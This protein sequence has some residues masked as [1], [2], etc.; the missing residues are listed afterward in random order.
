M[1][2]EGGA[3]AIVQGDRLGTLAP[4]KAADVIYLQVVSDRS[5][6]LYCYSS[7]GHRYT[8]SARDNRW[9]F[10]FRIWARGMSGSRHWFDAD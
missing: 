10:N 2:T 5:V 8:A 7:R 6:R 1:A 3:R 9:R 4:G